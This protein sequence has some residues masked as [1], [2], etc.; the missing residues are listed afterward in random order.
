MLGESFLEVRPMNQTQAIR[1][2]LWWLVLSIPFF[3]AGFVLALFFMVVEI[4]RVGAS[5]AYAGVPGQMDVDLKKNLSYT[6]FLEQTLGG[7]SNPSPL[8]AVKSNVRCELHEL[9]Y[10]EQIPMSPPSG[11]TNYNYGDRAGID[12]LNFTVPRDG[13]YLLACQDNRGK[14]GPPLRIAV[15]SGAAEA[16]ATAAEKALVSFCGGGIVALL[17][18]VR[19]LML[20]DQSKREIRALGLRPA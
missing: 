9:P 8:I 4:Q 2:S 6:V 12:F 11:S 13:T 10:G 14:P 16:I 7:S 1:P 19:V 5:L 18:F 15:G 17:I 3:L 20:R